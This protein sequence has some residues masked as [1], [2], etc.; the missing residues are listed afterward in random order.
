MF[1]AMHDK[2]RSISVKVLF[3]PALSFLFFLPSLSGGAA[4]ADSPGSRLNVLLIT[5]DTLRRHRKS[6]GLFKG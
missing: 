6:P 3:R 1:F 2:K 4:P 5:I